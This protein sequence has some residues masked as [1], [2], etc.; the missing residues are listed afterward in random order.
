MIWSIHSCFSSCQLNIDNRH[1]PIINSKCFAHF[2]LHLEN[3]NATNDWCVLRRLRIFRQNLRLSMILWHGFG[4]HFQLGW[5]FLN[6]NKRVRKKKVNPLSTKK[7]N[8][9]K[10][11][12]FRLKNIA[13]ILFLTTLIVVFHFSWSLSFFLESYF[14][15]RELGFSFLFSIINYHFWQSANLAFFRSESTLYK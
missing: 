12:V 11:K 7:T 5:E 1:V 9:K 15:G 14:L 4:N 2:R 3:W 13:S 8:K 10:K 6:E